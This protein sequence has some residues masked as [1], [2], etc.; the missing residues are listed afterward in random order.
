MLTEET[1][2][3][4][5]S[6]LLGR[7]VGSSEVATWHAI[8]SL[9]GAHAELGKYL[10]WMFIGDETKVQANEA[11]LTQLSYGFAAIEDR[12][13][14]ERIKEVAQVQTQSLNE[15]ADSIGLSR[16][17]VKRLSYVVDS[18]PRLNTLLK[19]SGSQLGMDSFLYAFFPKQYN[20]AILFR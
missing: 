9:V 13:L 10:L 17:Q 11:Y 12:A 16:A 2:T 6:S 15:L 5:I 3:A 4:R 20:Q 14:K 8:K 7:E 1:F 18:N 19:W